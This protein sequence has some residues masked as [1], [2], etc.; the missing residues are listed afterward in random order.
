MEQDHNQEAHDQVNQ[1]AEGKKEIVKLEQDKQ[2]RFF[3]T[4]TGVGG[5]EIG[6]H[7]AIPNS[8][9]VGMCEI[10][11]HAS[12]VLRYRFKGVKNYGDIRK[13]NDTR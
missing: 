3:S 2:I 5:F 6:I 7:N 13:I 12:N 10:D 9:C 8:K 1:G 4:F 11:K